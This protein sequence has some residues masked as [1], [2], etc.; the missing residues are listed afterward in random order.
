MELEI[1]KAFQ[2]GIAAHKRGDLEEAEKLYTAILKVQ[3]KH[4]DANHNMGV[5]AARLHRVQEALTFFKVALDINPKIERL[6]LKLVG[7]PNTE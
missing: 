5:L 1:D 2:E 7:I 3:P 6:L 4:P